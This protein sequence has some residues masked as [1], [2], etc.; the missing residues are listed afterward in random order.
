MKIGYYQKSR[1]HPKYS[2]SKRPGTT[3]LIHVQ[4]T[5]NV[6]KDDEETKSL[7]NEKGPICLA[8]L[9][10]QINFAAMLGIHLFLKQNPLF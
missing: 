1:V 6:S 5:M 9:S 8:V 2:H 4:N 10:C 3:R 7:S